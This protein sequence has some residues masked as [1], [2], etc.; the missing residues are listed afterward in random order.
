MDRQQPDAPARQ[1]KME[2]GPACVNR[3]LLNARIRV[4]AYTRVLDGKMMAR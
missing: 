4:H 3:A 2:A 1:M